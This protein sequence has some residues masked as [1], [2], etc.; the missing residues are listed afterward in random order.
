LGVA[1]PQGKLSRRA[2]FSGFKQRRTIMQEEFLKIMSAVADRIEKARWGY[3]E[4]ATAENAF[5]RAKEAVVDAIRD[6]IEVQR[7]KDK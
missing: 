5:D 1:S 6:E 3:S 4:E 7:R 2:F